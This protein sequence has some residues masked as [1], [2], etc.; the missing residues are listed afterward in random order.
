V[1]GG[2]DR[3]AIARAIAAGVANVPGVARLDPGTGVEVATQYAG[4]KV[5]GVAVRPDRIV[6]RV[7]LDR[8]PVAPVADHAH[9]V[10]QTVL[11]A[12][13]WSRPVE[14]VV[15]D[16]DL[17]QLPEPAAERAGERSDAVHGRPP[18]PVADS[19]GPQAAADGAPVPGAGHEEAW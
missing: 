19:P 3:G 18:E 4:G 16:V 8:L 7:V 14:L 11:R 13:G 5:P 6:V 17:D 12:V 2:Q 9:M 10:A 15:A 1:N